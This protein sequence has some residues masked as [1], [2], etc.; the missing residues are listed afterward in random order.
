MLLAEEVSWAEVFVVETA[1]LSKRGQQATLDFIESQYPVVKNTLMGLE[2]QLKEEQD[3]YD[4]ALPK[5]ERSWS[6]RIVDFSAES[7]R[8][9]RE[10]EKET[11]RLRLEFTG[12]DR[13]HPPRIL[14]HLCEAQ[15]IG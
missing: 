7:E 3:Y 9:Q 2:S 5:L 12:H 1:P 15:K 8:L 13:N 11:E 14:S 6:W 10:H 4:Q